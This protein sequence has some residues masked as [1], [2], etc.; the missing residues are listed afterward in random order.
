[1]AN[2]LYASQGDRLLPRERIEIFCRNSVCVI[3]NFRSLFFAKEG[4][5]KKKWSL[6]LDRGYEREFRIFFDRLK[7]GNPPLDIK[8]NIYATLTTFAIVDSVKT[9]RPQVVNAYLNSI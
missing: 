1:V 9:G 2:I 8:E 5:S 3:D 7:Q 6:S 4:R